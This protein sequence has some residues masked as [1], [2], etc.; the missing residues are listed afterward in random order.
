MKIFWHL[1]TDDPPECYKS[2]KKQQQWKTTDSKIES[3]PGFK[4]PVGDKEEK[5]GWIYA[6]RTQMVHIQ[7][8]CCEG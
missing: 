4:P 2:Q 7:N 5:E 3:K 6:K 8:F 1:I